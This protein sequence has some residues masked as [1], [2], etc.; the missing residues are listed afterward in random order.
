MA[1]IDLSAI[2]ASMESTNTFIPTAGLV[3]LL[4]MLTYFFLVVA[5]FVFLGLFLF[6]VLASRA[7]LLANPKRWLMPVLITIAA[8]VSGLIYFVI[9]S[10]YYTMLADLAPV[11]GPRRPPNA[12]PRV[13]QCYWAVPVHGLVYYYA[14]FAVS[15]GIDAPDQA[16]EKRP[17]GNGFA[18][19]WPIAGS[20][21]L[22]G[23]SAT[24][25]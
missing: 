13:V 14:D 16:A 12:H 11:T 17:S 19:V 4:P 25:V 22:L 7:Q 5:A 1:G 10:H 6:G 9:Q 2:F 24:L 21:R 23:P 15:T 3:G 8:A 18:G 20:G